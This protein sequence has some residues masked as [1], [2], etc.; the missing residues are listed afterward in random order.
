MLDRIVKRAKRVLGDHDPL[1]VPFTL[2][3]GLALGEMSNENV[4]EG[5]GELGCTAY[6]GTGMREGGDSVRQAS[7]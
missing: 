3:W 7:G 4:V 1:D 5:F 6:N 2:P